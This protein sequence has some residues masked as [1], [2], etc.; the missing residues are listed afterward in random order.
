MFGISEAT[1]K[2]V[3]EEYPIGCRVELVHMDDPYNIIRSSF[4]AAKVPSVGSTIVPRSMFPGI[5]VP[6]WVL[7]TAKTPAE[8]WPTNERRHSGSA[9]L[10]RGQPLR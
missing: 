5:A 2:R 4:L 6:A 10:R 1:V 7:S 3:R 8:R 9:I